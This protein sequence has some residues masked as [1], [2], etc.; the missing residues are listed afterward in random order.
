MNARRLITIGGSAGGVEALLALAAGLPAQL[1][2][3]VLVVLHIGPHRSVLPELLAGAG[4]LPAAHARDGEPPLAS[5]IYVAPPD[6]HLLLGG[7]LL[8]LSHGAKENHTRPA[9]D[10]LFRSAAQSGGGRVIGVLLS[11]LLD[12]GCAGLQAI[13]ACG[14]IA[15]VQ[16]P[17][18]AQEPSMPEQA[19]R[20]AGADHVLPAQ[21]MGPLLAEL[22]KR[23]GRAAP[24][25]AA[26]WPGGL[27][28]STR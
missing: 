19:L 23:G 3:A 20:R 27:E 15:V 12:D 22:V 17:S 13:R 14:G 16:S 24:A 2:A 9:I 6:Q 10:P 26:R 5:R 18:D 28:T 21:V 7:G 4:P 1:Q 25:G 11:G 8:R